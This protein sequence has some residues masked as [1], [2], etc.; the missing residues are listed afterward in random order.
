MAWCKWNIARKDC[1]IPEPMWYKKFGEGGLSGG[2][3]AETEMQREH[4]ETRY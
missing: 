4:K 2:A 3:S 1:M